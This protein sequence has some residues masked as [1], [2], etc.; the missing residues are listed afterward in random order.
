MENARPLYPLAFEGLPKTPDFPSMEEEILSYWR[1]GKIFE[2]SLKEREGARDFVFFD[3][4]PFA[5]GLPHYGHLLTG[6][7]KDV[8]PRYQTMRGKRVERVFNWDTHG[9][10]AELEAEREMGLTSKA[11]I[12]KMGVASFNRKCRESVLKYSSEW[13]RYINRQGRW[14]SFESGIKTMDLS[15]MESVIWAFKELYKKGLIYESERVLPYCPVDET[16]LSNHELHMDSDVYRP[17]QDR[18]VTVA[19]RLKNS[20]DY[21]LFWTTTPWTV[22]S[23]LAMAVGPEIDYARVECEKGPLAGKSV[24]IAKNRIPAYKKALGDVKI[25]RVIKGKDMEGWEY[26]PPTDFLQD[27]DAPYFPGPNAWKVY[28]APFVTQDDGTGIVHQAPYGEDDMETIHSH[29]IFP[30]DL[31]DPSARFREPVR[32][33]LGLGV[34]EASGK[35][36]RD[37]KD[38]SGPFARIPEDRRPVLVEDKDFVHSYPHCWRCGSPLIYKPVSSWF[39]KVTAIKDKLLKGNQKIN[40]IPENVKNGQFGKWLEGARDWSVTRNR[41][42]GTPIPIW[43][44]TD[45]AYPRIDV[46]GSLEEIEKDFGRLPVNEAGEVDLHRPWV[47]EL[48]RPNP[49]DPTG[50]SEMRRVKDVLDV[51]F[52]SACISFAQKHYP[53]EHKEEFLSRFPAD[54]V[55]EYI[56]QTRGWF[57]VQNVMTEALFDDVPFKN[58]VCHGIVLG[59][60]GNKM[61][62]HLRNYPDVSEVFD[63]SGSDALRWF[64]MSSPILRGGN[65]IVTSQGIKDAAR[66]VLIP[67]WNAYSF[68]AL[69]ANAC[70]G[71]KGYRAHEVKEG[72]DL[73]EL[74]RFI[75]SSLASA[76]SGIKIAL[77]AFSIAEACRVA[78]D[79][80]DCLTN[81]YIRNSRQRFWREDK[82]AFDT[83]YTVLET[84][85]KAAAPLLPFECE[86]IFRSL[87]GKDSVHLEDWP[88]SSSL[89]TWKDPALEGEMNSAREIVSLALSIRKEQNI[90]VRQPLSKLA[91]VTGKEGLQRFEKIIKREMDVKEVEFL[92]FPEAKEEGFEVEK[93]LALNPRAL[94]PRLGGKVQNVI[95]A[96]KAGDW[97]E[98]GGKVEVCLAGE[99]VE[100]LKGEYSL[101]S[102][103]SLPKSSF[104]KPLSDGGFVILDCAI[105]EDLEEEGI[106]RDF[107][108]Q[109]QE[110]RK[111]AGFKITDRIRLSAKAPEGVLG[112]LEKFREEIARETLA[113]EEKLESGEKTE[114]SLEL[115]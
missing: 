68:F 20:E 41:Y 52:D 16:P 63:E 43:V 50:R 27:P 49:D 10:P 82:A 55:V 5:N 11:D 110:E 112:A 28:T 111:K 12:D 106:A 59:S 97:K 66:K 83:L 58:V 60:D 1:E 57:Y 39:V 32:D 105:D 54:F 84:F 19:V 92:S 9:L 46:Y 34:F 72:E 94:G 31:T 113:V 61:S 7:A 74:D 45:P 75:L 100:L 23:N 17:R 2:R 77:D 115:A 89:D 87:T 67:F 6:Y 81:W 44:S 86:A 71:Q 14:V 51:W 104:A 4:P 93:K 64:L 76:V 53:F 21:L 26:W 85:S 47:D 79:F 99:K 35:I 80:I 33:Y 114:I 36:I 13:E 18:T 38:A 102:T 70:D 42:W 69:Y 108:R 29:A 103:L 25:E 101:S 65:L 22:P 95:R 109:V 78:G 48:V 24:W 73:T 8:I 3:G 96:A 40:W 88:N 15:Y 62:K 37:F 56:G 107:I 90:R 30:F 91:V 98:E